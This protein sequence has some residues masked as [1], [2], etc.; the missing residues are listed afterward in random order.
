[1]NVVTGDAKA[2]EAYFNGAGRCSQCHSPAGDL[3]HIASKFDA[4]DLQAQ[5]LY[6][7]RADDQP[8]VTVTPRSGAAIT[9]KLKRIDDFTVSLWDG[10]GEYRSF[11]R[12][13]VKVEI[14]DPLAGHRELLAQYSDADMHNLLAYLVT[15][16]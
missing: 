4:A 15:L 6:P 7:A 3:A 8:S 5:F 10:S 9:G 1:M 12:N 16:K 13:D 11:S 14:K 2:G